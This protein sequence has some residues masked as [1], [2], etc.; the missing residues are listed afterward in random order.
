M[1]ALTVAEE[2][3]ELQGRGCI[4]TLD[5]ST[6]ALFELYEMRPADKRFQAAFTLQ[7]TNDKLDPQLKTDSVDS[8][9]ARLSGVWPY[10]GPEDLPWG[11]RW[12]K[13][14]DPDNLLIA[15]Y[16]EISRS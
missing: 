16:Q 3:D 10:E 11:Q 9:A 2:W 12:I 6:S 13:L 15:I 8:W 4:L 5:A 7:L 1:L 14:R